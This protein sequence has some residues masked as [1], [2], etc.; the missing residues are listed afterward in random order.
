MVPNRQLRLRNM[1]R[2]ILGS[3]TLQLELQVH[4]EI[5]DDVVQWQREASAFT[6]ILEIGPQVVADHVVD[7]ALVTM[8]IAA[9]IAPEI[10]Q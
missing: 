4:L 3:P 6:T 1:V 8:M 7:T 9:V 10:L 5:P 2:M